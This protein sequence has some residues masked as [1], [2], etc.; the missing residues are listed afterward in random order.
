M[1]TFTTATN[2]KRIHSEGQLDVFMGTFDV[3]SGDTTGSIQVPLTNVLYFEATGAYKHTATV[4]GS[5]TT[6][7][8][9][10]PDPGETLTLTWIAIGRP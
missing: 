2:A 3:I 1:S 7:V 5:I 4:S 9:T 6:Y 10:I 8:V